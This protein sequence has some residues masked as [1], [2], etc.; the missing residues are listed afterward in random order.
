[1]VKNLPEKVAVKQA[2]QTLPVW[3][4]FA[5]HCWVLKTLTTESTYGG[6]V[7]ITTFNDTTNKWR[8][9]PKVSFVNTGEQDTCHTLVWIMNQSMVTTIFQEGPCH[10][11]EYMLT[12]IDCD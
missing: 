8:T 9:L 10:E 5:C 12:K 3:W 1:M 11:V 4:Y 2:K 7:M 6:L